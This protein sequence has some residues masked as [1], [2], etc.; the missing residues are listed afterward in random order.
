MPRATFFP[1]TMLLSWFSGVEERLRK[2]ILQLDAV[3]EARSEHGR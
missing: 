1:C 2:A 3:P